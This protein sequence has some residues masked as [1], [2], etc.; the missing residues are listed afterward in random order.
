MCRPPSRR[1]SGFSSRA[2]SCGTAASGSKP[3]STLRSVTTLA[4]GNHLASQPPQNV[5]SGDGGRR[6][7]SLVSKS[8]PMHKFSQV[9]FNGT[10]I[11]ERTV[12]IRRTSFNELAMQTRRDAARQFLTLLPAVQGKKVSQ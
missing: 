6:L 9:F 2:L 7:N 3:R 10:E 5:G 4:W 12:V 11:K 1:C 8:P